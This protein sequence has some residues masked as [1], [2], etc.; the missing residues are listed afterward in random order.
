MQLLSGFDAAVTWL[1]I[2]GGYA[3]AAALVI[4]GVYLALF[5][6]PG[7]PFSRARQFVGCVLIAAGAVLAAYNLGR[8]TGA[9]ACEAAWRTKNYEAR[10]ARLQQEAEAKNI[11]A[12]TAAEKAQQ[13]A[14]EKDELQEQIVQYQ[15]AASSFAACRRAT[16]DDDRRLCN[17]AGR[18]SPACSDPR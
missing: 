14:S 16:D 2:A 4:G 9:E 11:A 8:Q 7:V 3:L 18:S 1:G 12:S 15:I 13:L 10:I 5:A 17:I 6:A